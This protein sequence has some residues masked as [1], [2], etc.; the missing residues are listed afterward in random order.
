M[1]I[2]LDYN[3]SAPIDERV[4]EEMLDVYK[5]SY[6]NADSR[7]H[8]HGD[9]ARLIVE[10]ARKR[11]ASLLSVN[12][13]EIFFHKRSDLRATILQSKDLKNMQMIQERNI[14]LQ[15]LLNIRLCL[16]L[17]SQCKKRDL[18]LI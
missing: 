11:V 15:L 9:H 6:G 1:G 3:A 13:T 4:L 10:N 17:L 14:L 16:R 12:T 2:Y 7:T 18:K 5:N 8:D